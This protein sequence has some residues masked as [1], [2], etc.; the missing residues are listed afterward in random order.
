MMDKIFLATDETKK[1][2][3]NLFTKVT[4]IGY[5]KGD[6][7]KQHEIK[8]LE[9]LHNQRFNQ[10]YIDKCSLLLYNS[11]RTRNY[12]FKRKHLDKVVYNY[13]DNY[14]LYITLPKFFKENKINQKS[15]TIDTIKNNTSSDKNLLSYS[16][17]KYNNYK[18]IYSWNNTI[19][20]DRT[21]NNQHYNII[22]DS[23][24]KNKINMMKFKLGM[25]NKKKWK[26]E[27]EPTEPTIEE[28]KTVYDKLKT[29][30]N[31]EKESVFPNLPKIKKGSPKE[32]NMTKTVSPKIKV[33]ATPEQISGF[34]PSLGST[35]SRGKLDHLTDKQKKNLFFISELG[36]FEHLEN[37][38]RK[39]N[40]MQSF[41][42]KKRNIMI[43]KDLFHY[44]NEKWSKITEEKNKNINEEKIKKC[45]ESIK[46]Q[47][48]EMKNKV[49]KLMNER[50][51][52]ENEI[53]KTFLN[54]D[55]FLR[56]SAINA[57]DKQKLNLFKKKNKVK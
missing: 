34:D 2:Q 7:E 41:N 14:N 40:L 43:C 21:K 52:T 50:F 27:S 47:L 26:E 53:Q 16:S 33:I 12:P 5:S 54:I 25:G 17:K 36:L 20:V 37:L 42:K 4:S 9:S 10:D 31:E 23:K 19:E 55:K 22:F 24:N 48:D 51:R 1:Y 38:K 35:I 30:F 18:P 46:I 8:M 49:D 32:I 15:R 44:D 6:F 28:Q 29:I 3:A 56:D 57:S 39:R 11:T 45:N 13:D